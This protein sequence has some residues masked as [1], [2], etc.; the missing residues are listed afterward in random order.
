MTR[1]RAATHDGDR[2]A[3]N[4]SV[5]RLSERDRV[6]VVV[7]DANV[8][9]RVEHAHVGRGSGVDDVEPF[10]VQHEADD[11]RERITLVADP[12]PSAT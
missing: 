9:R 6:A 4:V 5:D 12:N 2:P 8:F 7:R 3:K 1:C 11:A 10:G